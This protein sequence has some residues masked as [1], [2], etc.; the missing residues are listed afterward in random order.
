M[1]IEI[2]SDRLNY[3][4]SQIEPLWAYSI[5]VHGDSIVVFRG[6]MDII[7]SNVKD[8]EDLLGNKAIKGGDMLHFIVERFDPPASIRLAYYMQR[9]LVI[10][11][12]DVLALH[13]ITTVRN[14]DDLFIDRGKLTVSIASAGTSSEKIH[15]GINIS[16]RGTPPEVE[17]AC[18]EGLGVEDVMALGEQIASTFVT[19][20]DDIESDIVK[21]K[22]L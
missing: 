20:T 18:L 19:E 3:N 9:L 4:G 5:G 6:A 13:G 22:G 7:E 10:C 16:C 15:M 17:V 2:L 11:T 1:R 8:L 12:R 14:G 21:T